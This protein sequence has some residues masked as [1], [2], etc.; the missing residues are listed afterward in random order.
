MPGEGERN[1]AARSL[2]RAADEGD[3]PAEI[4]RIRT[5]HA[6]APLMTIITAV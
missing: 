6:S 3:L 4:Q 5:D 2:S 1:R